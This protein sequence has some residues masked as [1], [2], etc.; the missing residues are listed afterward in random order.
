MTDN[1]PPA[2]IANSS[3]GVRNTAFVTLAILAGVA[4]FKVSVISIGN[5]SAGHTAVIW[6]DDGTDS[7]RVFDSDAAACKRTGNPS[8]FCEAGLALAIQSR[9]LRLIHLPY[10]KTY[11]SIVDGS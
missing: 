11:A 3:H 7:L 6:K 1:T 8:F 10:S 4:I 5:E 2:P 9:Q